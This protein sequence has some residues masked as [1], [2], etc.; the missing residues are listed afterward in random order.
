MS[1][2]LQLPI[3]EWAALVL[4]H[5]HEGFAVSERG[6]AAERAHNWIAQELDRLVPGWRNTIWLSE[7]RKSSR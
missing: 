5:M 3:E 4:E 7:K 2:G 1:I 6:R